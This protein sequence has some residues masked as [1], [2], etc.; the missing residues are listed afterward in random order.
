LHKGIY[1]ER[2]A[3]IKDVC[4]NIDM[5]VIR[6]NWQAL[7]VTATTA[8][9][10]VS[11]YT[12]PLDPI[13][14]PPDPIQQPTADIVELNEINHDEPNEPAASPYSYSSCPPPVRPKKRSRIIE[15]QG[16]LNQFSFSSSSLVVGGA[17][18][19]SLVFIMSA[20]KGI[21][22]ARPGQDSLSGFY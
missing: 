22:G 6:K 10:P 16:L 13:Q 11:S 2:R 20:G 7:P 18:I 17:V 1:T 21:V 9:A 14:Q 8:T 3:S 5:V 12:P 4:T 15:Q 19:A